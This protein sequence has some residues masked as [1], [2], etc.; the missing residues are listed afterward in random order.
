MDPANHRPI[1]LTICICKTM[2]QMMND[3]LVWFLESNNLLTNLQCGF[4]QG[5]S[6][7]DHLVQLESYIRDPFL[8]L[9]HVVT[10]FFDL[11]KAYKIT[12]QYG[13]LKDLFDFG[14]NDCYV[15]VRSGSTLSGT[16]DGVPQGSTFSV[17]LSFIKINS[18][19]SCMETDTE[20]SLYVDDPQQCL[21]KLDKWANT[22]GFKFSKTKTVCMYFCQL[23]DLH[24]DPKSSDLCRKRV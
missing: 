10:V 21:N 6:T 1:S 22:N 20:E 19:V 13:F 9:K 5:R 18:I 23:Y 17:T 3:R 2:E 12:W 8:E 24:P 11:E 16:G 15:S 7:I 14:F 4:R